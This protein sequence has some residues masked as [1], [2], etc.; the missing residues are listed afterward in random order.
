MT[1]VV[2]DGLLK[3]ADVCRLLAVS[4]TWVYAAASEGRIPSIRLGG[5]EGPL[6]FVRADIE[7]WLQEARAEWT[8]GRSKSGR[9]A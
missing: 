6:R 5:P 3:P 1:T 2:E 9:A 4:R 8:P 7:Q